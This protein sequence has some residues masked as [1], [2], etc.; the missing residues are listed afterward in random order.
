MQEILLTSNNLQDELN[1]SLLDIFENLSSLEDKLLYVA[2]LKGCLMNY[3]II[4]HL[5]G[6]N[7]RYLLELSIK[8]CISVSYDVLPH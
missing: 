2:D 6:L 3:T 1:E 4:E 7:H 8:L 5:T